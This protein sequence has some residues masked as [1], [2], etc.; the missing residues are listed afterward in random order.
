MCGLTGQLAFPRADTQAVARATELLAHRGPDG[1]GTLDEGCLAIGHVRLSIIDVAGGAQPIWNEDR[2][3][4]VVFNGEIYNHKALH[5]ELQ[6]RH[7][8]KTRSDTEVMV[9][10]YEER[11]EAMFPLLRGMFALAIW[12]ANKRTLLLARDA[13][14][15]K[16][17]VYA[18]PDA[19]EFQGQDGDRCA[20]GPRGISFGSELTAVRSLAPSAEVDRAALEQYLALLYVP[21]PRT[22]LR[23][24][25]KLPAGHVLRASE[26]GVSV[27]R[28]YTPPRPGIGTRPDRELLQATLQ[29]AVTLRLESDVPV[30]ALL[31]GGLDSSAVVALLAKTV[32]PGLRTFSVGF[33]AADDE[34]PYARLVAERYQTAHRELVLTLDALAHTEAALAANPEP[35]GDSSIVPMLAVSKAVA[36]EVKVVL[37]G[38]GGDELFGGYGRVRTAGRLPHSRLLGRA[39]SFAA[40][41]AGG[42][43]RGLL[44]AGQAL[45]T[46]GL[47][48]AL[49]LWEVFQVRER[50]AL[51]GE[52]AP[53]SFPLDLDDATDADAAL[54]FDLGVYLP[55]DLLFKADT[56]S[57]HASLEARAPFLDVPLATLAI[58]P[59]A[60]EKFAHPEGKSLLRDAIHELLPA[61]ILARK[62]RGFGAPVASWLPGP[63]RPLITDLVRAP[64][65]R[66]KQHLDATAVDACVDESLAARGNPHQAFALLA[67]EAWLRQ[68]KL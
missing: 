16:P 31:S 60:G 47:S 24:V 37:T 51:L 67:L 25:K 5:A 61:P 12:D 62:K 33:G 42:K 66:L 29:E 26:Q 3:V 19:P 55:D 49:S 7:T 40:P 10:L 48:R 15:E 64:T 34:L 63:L 14:G 52:A 46:R 43:E 20:L 30:A 8:F 44:R 39:L 4:A 27:R 45:S 13:F 2:T 1:R 58:P 11:G 65:A 22:I 23:G 54:A 35:F 41:F 57:M 21:A 28:W 59:P 9:H 38:D 68:A 32:G 53:L 18:L 6:G 50:E 56:A 36:R 17:L